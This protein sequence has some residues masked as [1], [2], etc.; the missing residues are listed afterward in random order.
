MIISESINFKTFTTFETMHFARVLREQRY[1]QLRPSNDLAVVRATIMQKLSS[2]FGES[3]AIKA[4]I[5]DSR[6][7]K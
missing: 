4:R 3:F 7:I 5:I 2:C 1:S 6:E